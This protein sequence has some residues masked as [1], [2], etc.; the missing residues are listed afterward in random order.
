MDV[1]Q[2]VVKIVCVF[3][4]RATL[5]VVVVLHISTLLVSTET[6]VIQRP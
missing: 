3:L 2:L 5:I 4:E 1:V 6:Q